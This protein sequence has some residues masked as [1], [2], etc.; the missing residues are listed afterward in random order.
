[1]EMKLLP[2]RTKLVWVWGL[3]GRL[4]G[5]RFYLDPRFV[6]KGVRL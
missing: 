3:S 6:P 1:M 4:M 5:V 2:D